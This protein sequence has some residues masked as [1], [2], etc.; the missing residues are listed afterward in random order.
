MRKD[1]MIASIKW[2]IV[3]MEAALAYCTAVPSYFSGETKQNRETPQPV[4]LSD[5]NQELPEY[6]APLSFRS[7]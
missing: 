4:L 5:S 1:T 2:E 3:W 6:Q 7:D